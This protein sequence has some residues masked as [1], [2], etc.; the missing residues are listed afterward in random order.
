MMNEGRSDALVS[1][2]CTATPIAIPELDLLVRYRLYIVFLNNILRANEIEK[3]SGIIP[4]WPDPQSF[5]KRGFR[6]S[7]N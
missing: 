2:S 7:Y 6:L 4:K 3:L 5:P 1:R